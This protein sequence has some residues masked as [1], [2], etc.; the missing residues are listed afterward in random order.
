MSSLASDSDQKSL[1][2]HPFFLSTSLFA[3]ASWV[4][5]LVSQAFAA[6]NFGRDAVATLWLAIILQLL[7]NIGMLYA[8]LSN[9][10]NLLRLQ[11]TT[12]SAM[13]VVLAA[14]GIDNNLFSGHRP[15]DA[16]AAIW[17]ILSVIDLLWI[18]VLC[19]DNR[20]SPVLRLFAEEARFR[21]SSDAHSLIWD[22]D[23][24][25][26][27]NL[28]HT[29][30]PDDKQL[31]PKSRSTLVSNNTAST[32]ISDSTAR[33]VS[34]VIQNVTNSPLS[35]LRPVMMDPHSNKSRLTVPVSIATGG[36]SSAPS[37]NYSYSQKAMALYD[38][39]DVVT[40]SEEGE[41]SFLK[42]ETLQVSRTYEK[43]WWP[44]R[45]A[46]GEVGVVPSNYL[47]IEG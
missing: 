42:G 35:G 33:P 2:F 4:A 43:K 1:I 16:I 37:S 7:V 34:P 39:T 46:N 19:S 9:S 45:K 14:L 41:L 47:R 32:P 12:F 3:H 27:H 30:L 5:A 23:E 17:I 18:L 11:I 20:N 6:A 28:T 25:Q 24:L 40:G 26:N 13:I 15:R 10:V 22:Q 8:L 38:C 36:S 44:A 21:L 31:A 29:P